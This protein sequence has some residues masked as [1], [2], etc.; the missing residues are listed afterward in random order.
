MATTMVTS[1]KAGETG[2]SVAPGKKHYSRVRVY[3]DYVV[4]GH[5]LKKSTA[6]ALAS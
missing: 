6:I 4:Q 2:A 5:S 3:G 1:S